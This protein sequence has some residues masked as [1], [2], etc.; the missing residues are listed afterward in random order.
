MTTE[1]ILT[2]LARTPKKLRWDVMHRAAVAAI[3]SRP[4]SEAAKYTAALR[5]LGYSAAADAHENLVWEASFCRGAVM[6][7]SA[8][9]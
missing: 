9:T 7:H 5:M 2:L 3:A 6:P 8:A 1:S 4:D